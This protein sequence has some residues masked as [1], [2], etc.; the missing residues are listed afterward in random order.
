MD[1]YNNSYGSASLIFGRQLLIGGIKSAIHTGLPVVPVLGLRGLG[2]LDLLGGQEVPVV[3]Q[4]AGLG[5]LVIDED[6]VGVVRV[7]DE[8]VQVGEHI[9]LAANVL[10]RRE[11]KILLLN[12]PGNNL[13]KTSITKTSKKNQIMAKFNYSKCIEM[14]FLSKRQHFIPRAHFMISVFFTTATTST[15]EWSCEC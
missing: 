7:E 1:P 5:L 14:H 13:Q 4:R 6:L 12:R 8:G 2:I 11:N 9:V 3:L 10:K 15:H